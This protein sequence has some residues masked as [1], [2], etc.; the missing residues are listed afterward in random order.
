MK[1]RHLWL[2]LPPLL[3]IVLL[4]SIYLPLRGLQ[5]ED[6]LLLTSAGS[7]SVTGDFRQFPPDRERTFSDK[8]DP[9]YWVAS[10][11]F[12]GDGTGRLVSRPFPASKWISLTVTGN[13]LS[14]GNSVYFRAEGEEARCPVRVCTE[15]FVWRRVT[16]ALPGTWSGRSIQLVAEAG[17]REK[18]DW[19]G[20]SSPRVPGSNAILRSELQSLAVLPAF[21]AALLLFLVPGLALA[22]RLT[23]SDWLRPALFLP[24]AVVLSCLVGYLG[25]WVYFFD[26]VA[27]RALSWIVLLGS[28]AACALGV[29]RDGPLRRMLLSREVLTPFTL[30]ALVG[31]FFLSLLY[32]VN[33][34]IGLATQ[35]RVRFFESTLAIDDEIPYLFAD[36]VFNHR[37]L[38]NALVDEWHGSDRPP[39][40]TGLTLL[41]LPLT[42]FGS[43]N[44]TASVCEPR[45]YC[46]IVGCALQCSWVPAAW[47]LLSVAGLPRPRA[48]IAFLLVLLSGFALVNTVFPWPKM[49]S[50]ALTIYA[51]TLGLFGRD[52][53]ARTFPV[54][55]AVLLGLSAALASLGHGGVAF[56][57][58][59]FGLFLLL[60]RFYPGLSRLA[61]AGAVY[62]AAMLPWALYQSRFDPPGN[63]LIRYHLAGNSPTWSDSRSLPLNLLDAY[64]GTDARTVLQNKLENLRVL[65]MPAADQYAWP[66]R[67]KP[68]EWPTD[69]VGFRRCDFLALFWTLGLLNAGW[70]VAAASI[71]R[72]LPGLDRRLS[73]AAPLL[74]LASVL[75]WVVLMFGPR[76]T[77]VHQGSYATFLLLFASLAACLASL[78]R[79]VAYVFLGLQAAVFTLGWLLTSPANSY[80]IPNWPSV[81][82]AAVFFAAIVRVCV[83]TPSHDVQPTEKMLAANF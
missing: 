43:D 75:V 51:I 3:A 12:G 30:T 61:V 42:R 4:G 71:W 40:Q 7:W 24:T 45:T 20:L 46:V 48:G 17:P 82:L 68:A 53:G 10:S 76:G 59:P 27:G 19:F 74:G 26:P 18:G 9:V 6:Q 11:R 78:P 39:L 31:L 22:A 21:A 70:L 58:L 1:R 83:G 35:P 52:V 37:D 63:L 5:A 73:V 44:R 36:R 28:M 34:Q 72:G 49:L 14:P 56:T 23:R 69:A 13:L 54:G 79:A 62:V 55:K 25:F 33:L 60:P 66:L 38:K 57:L 32:S 8:I 15:E 64:R 77:V 29:R 16:L 80:G 47:A 65:F 2:G 81:F 41:Q 67:G 50:A